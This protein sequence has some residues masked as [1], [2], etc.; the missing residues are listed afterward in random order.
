[1]DHGEAGVARG[2]PVEDG[3]GPVGGAVV[4]RHHL[5]VG[6]VLGQQRPDGRLD[7]A[8]LVAAGDHHR[9]RRRRRVRRLLPEVGQRPVRQ[10]G[11]HGDREPASEREGGE[12]EEEAGHRRHL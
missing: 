5:E 6:Q 12:G 3:A 2:Q 10:P 8:G 1:M 9:E 7:V 11:Q 4:D